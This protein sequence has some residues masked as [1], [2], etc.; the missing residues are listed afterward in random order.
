MDIK[1]EKLELVR[2]LLDTNNKKLLMKIKG[3]LTRERSDE[4]EYLQ[5]TEANRQHLE[6][7]IRQVAEGKTTPVSVDSL[8]Q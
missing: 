4:T 6:E 5:S 2:L 3:I 1:A 8:W 7:G